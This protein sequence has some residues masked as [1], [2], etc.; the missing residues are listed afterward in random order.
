MD[1]VNNSNNTFQNIAKT[2][3]IHEDNDLDQAGKV[4]NIY[5]TYG[6]IISTNKKISF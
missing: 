4:R 5:I 1:T 2:F 3:N 6:F